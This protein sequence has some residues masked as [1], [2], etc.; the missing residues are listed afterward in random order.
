MS[1]KVMIVVA[2]IV[3]LIL[4]TA[5]PKWESFKMDPLT[6]QEITR[7]GNYKRFAEWAVF[8]S[9]ATPL[10][11]GRVCWYF[12]D[13]K[14][15]PKVLDGNQVDEVET[16]T[17]VN[18]TIKK[19]EVHSVT[20]YGP[21]LPCQGQF[22]E[23]KQFYVPKP[24]EPSPEAQAQAAIEQIDET[25]ATDAP[26]MAAALKAMITKDFPQLNDPNYVK[27]VYHPDPS[28]IQA[29]EADMDM[30]MSEIRDMNDDIEEERMREEMSM[31][32]HLLDGEEMG[33]GQ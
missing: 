31:S 33:D 10:Q 18:G 28:D 29:S 4:S 32:H 27:S 26:Q 12:L 21:E 30:M 16:I 22:F 9:T 24:P 3:L 13:G 1:R 23:P 2:A 6:F 8:Y 11:R 14:W 7:I 15:V 5:S 19:R 17:R 20:I 25:I